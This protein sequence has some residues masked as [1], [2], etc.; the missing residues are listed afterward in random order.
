[1]MQLV[2]VLLLLF[3]YLSEGCE[4]ILN[5]PF[6]DDLDEGIDDVIAD[7]YRGDVA[8]I[9][10]LFI[11]LDGHKVNYGELADNWLFQKYRK[12]SGMLMQ[13][14]PEK[15]EEEARKGFFI[16]VYNFF[17]I[18]AVIEYAENYGMPN[19]TKSIPEFWDKYCYN[20]GG[21][22]YSL[23]DIEHGVLR[24]N[25]GTDNHP[26]F[27]ETDPRLEVAMMELDQRVHFTLNCGGL[28]CPAINV[29][30]VTGEISEELDNAGFDFLEKE[31]NISITET[32]SVVEM[33][34]ILDWYQTDFGE[35]EREML[36][37]IKEHVSD[38]DMKDEIEEVLK[39]EFVVV[40]EEYD[41]TLNNF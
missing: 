22:D 34:K 21:L 32:G 10:E 41:W 25:K 16:N 30:S 17:T 20:I 29:Y 37:W 15:L 35:D 26:P 40:Y 5:R 11:S 23:N 24:A 12:D 4:H 28:S 2:T 33:S 13:M 39:G 18:H 9:L 27:E 3:N 36:D 14:R 7:M 1:M 38:P 8:D 6:T 19:S 31:V